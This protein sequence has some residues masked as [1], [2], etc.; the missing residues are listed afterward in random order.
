MWDLLGALFEILG[1]FPGRRVTVAD[2]YEMKRRARE[3]RRRDKERAD[4]TKG[5]ATPASDVCKRCGRAI[6]VNPAVSADVLEGMH[7]LCFH[8]EFEHGETDPDLPCSDFTGCPWW[9]IRHYEDKLR[10]LGVD[11]AIVRQEAIHRI[12]SERY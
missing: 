5:I 4:A 6:L 10:E 1:A 11:P 8:L 7:W 3:L 12:S 2:R 9:T